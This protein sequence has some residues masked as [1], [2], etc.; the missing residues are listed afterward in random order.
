MTPINQLMPL[1]DKG[2][3]AL[4]IQE[5]LQGYLMMLVDG[6]GDTVLWLW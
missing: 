5:C 3:N 2:E 4:S 6:D 1:T